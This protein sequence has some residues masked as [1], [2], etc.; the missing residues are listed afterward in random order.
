MLGG[1]RTEVRPALNRWS[2]SGKRGT[3]AT[4][5]LPIRLSVALELSVSLLFLWGPA[6]LE[7]ATR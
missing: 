7:R 2:L 5:V 6:G 4:Y 1:N 3:S